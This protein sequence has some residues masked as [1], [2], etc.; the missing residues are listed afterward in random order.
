MK[1]ILA[2]VLISLCVNAY[3]RA[4]NYPFNEIKQDPEFVNTNEIWG[5]I[6][7]LHLTENGTD[8]VIKFAYEETK[9]HVNTKLDKAVWKQNQ[10]VYLDKNDGHLKLNINAPHM[11]KEDSNYG[12]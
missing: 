4:W 8:L 7:Q 9:L 1:K 5:K 2:L 10:T 12:Q 11:G 3:A 6:K